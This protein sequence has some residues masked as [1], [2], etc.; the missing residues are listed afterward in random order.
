[1]SYLYLSELCCVAGSF[2]CLKAIPKVFSVEEGSELSWEIP[3]WNTGEY[4]HRACSYKLSKWTFHKLH[5]KEFGSV[6]VAEDIQL[7]EWT[8]V[9][10]LVQRTTLACLLTRI[11]LQVK[12]KFQ[13][14]GPCPLRP[15]S[16]HEFSITEM[17]LQTCSPLC[18]NLSE[19]KKSFLSLSGTS[20]R[21]PV[22]TT[23]VTLPIHTFNTETFGWFLFQ[24]INTIHEYIADQCLFPTYP[25]AFG[26]F[27]VQQVNK[28]PPRASVLRKTTHAHF[29]LRFSSKD[30]S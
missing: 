6:M 19:H 5:K 21:D 15:G 3:I 7:Y 13:C 29:P 27:L 24:K 16:M 30:G 11:L 4:Q 10:M 23:R 25:Q 12:E 22:H 9:P 14:A 26:S 1:M 2:L 20:S 8:P 18:R 28:Q 17:V